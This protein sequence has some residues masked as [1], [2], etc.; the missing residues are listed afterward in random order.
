M[1]FDSEITIALLIRWNMMYTVSCLYEIERQSVCDVA[2]TYT[3][4]KCRSRD[5]QKGLLVNI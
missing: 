4:A 1:K 3:P 2:N 5:I